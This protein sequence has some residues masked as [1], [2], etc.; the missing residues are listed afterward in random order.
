MY[1]NIHALQEISLPCND[2]CSYPVLLPVMGTQSTGKYDRSGL[3]LK[4]ILSAALHE[5]NRPG[6]KSSPNTFPHVRNPGKK[7]KN[8]PVSVRSYMLQGKTH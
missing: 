5:Q 3:A 8:S 4:S 6:T 7:G 1:D 2:L